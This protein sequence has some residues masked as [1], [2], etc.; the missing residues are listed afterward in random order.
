MSWKELWSSDLQDSLPLR[1]IVA[2]LFLAGCAAVPL[3][4]STIPHPSSRSGPSAKHEYQEA[5]GVIHVH[6]T[7]SDGLLPVD[8]IA[9]IANAQGLDYLIITDHNTLQGRREGKQGWHGRT[10]VLIDDEISTRGGHYLALRL[11]KE[12]P[13]L[14]DTRWTMEAVSAQG[15]L[16]FIAHPFWPRRPWKDLQVRGM[17]GLEIYNAVGDM[18]G[19]KI[20]W[21]GPWLILTGSEFSI[22]QW[23]TR[24]K[25]SLDL[26]DTTLARGDRVVG[27]GSTD[28][29][30]LRRWGMRL[31]PYATLFKLV[32]THLLLPEISEKAIYNALAGGHAFVAHDMVAEAKGF[33]FAAV[34]RDKVAG[35]MGD[36]VIWGRGL[37]LYAYLPS[38]GNLVLFK[39]GRPAAK[40]RGQQIWF[41][42]PGPGV[43]RVE[44]TRSGKP[45]IYSNPIY[46]IE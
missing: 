13:R 27:I 5:V 29:H 15:G 10:L 20:L 38:P 9:R 26:W 24:Q 3:E 35:I 43:Y 42:V 28:A 16:G 39:D 8:R 34:E 1:F 36:Q 30:G 7:Y 37:R 31:G 14:Q 6:S 12:V 19:K 25:E 18:T 11:A 21:L 2:A 40:E 17:T 45:W 4:S 33:S 41:D 46:V 22:T 32:R 23:L 44:A